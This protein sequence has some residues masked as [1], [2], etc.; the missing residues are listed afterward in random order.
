MFL[1]VCRIGPQQQHEP[2]DDINDCALAFPLNKVC[3]TQGC[4]NFTDV[5]LRRVEIDSPLLS[6]GVIL[7]NITNPMDV[8]FE[9]VVVTNGEWGGEFPFGGTYLCNNTD[10]KLVGTVDPAPVCVEGPPDASL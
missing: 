5:V 1:F 7:G 10:M 6:P 4:V 9:D 2:G 3:Y 8:T